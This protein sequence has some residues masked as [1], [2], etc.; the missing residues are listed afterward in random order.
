MAFDTEKYSAD[1]LILSDEG[2]PIRRA[3]CSLLSVCLSFGRLYCL[4]LSQRWAPA[5][6]FSRGGGTFFLKKYTILFSRRPQ[7]TGVDCNC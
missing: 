5:G 3:I 7:N 1:Q 4:L 6:L 2:T